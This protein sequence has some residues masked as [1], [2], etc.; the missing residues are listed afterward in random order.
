[1]VTILSSVSYLTRVLIY[2][3]QIIN[4]VEHVFMCLL[5]ICVSLLYIT[6]I[7]NLKKKIKNELI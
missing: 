3:S 2:I 7:W 6:Y 1:M 5:A 4:D